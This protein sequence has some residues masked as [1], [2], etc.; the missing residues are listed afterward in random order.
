M[1]NQ[2]ILRKTSNAE[3]YK[4]MEESGIEFMFSMG[5]PWETFVG[6]YSNSHQI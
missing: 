5:K 6:P 1:Y 4:K 2:S 3:I